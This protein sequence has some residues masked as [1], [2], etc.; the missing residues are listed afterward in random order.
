MRRCGAIRLVGDMVRWIGVI[1]KLA[2]AVTRDGPR[3]SVIRDPVAEFGALIEEVK[4]ASDSPLEG[5]GF[6]LS[7]PRWDDGSVGPR[8]HPN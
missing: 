2:T 8:P 7:V 3:G 1:N 6:E 4:F 5:N